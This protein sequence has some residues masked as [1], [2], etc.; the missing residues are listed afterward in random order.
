LYA[1]TGFSGS[2]PTQ[3]SITM[4]WALNPM[5]TG[6][7][8]Q[9][10]TINGSWSSNYNPGNVA[11][12]TFTGLAKD[13][14]YEF[15]IKATNAAGT[16]VES[17]YTDALLVRTLADRPLA[18]TNLVASIQTEDSLTISWTQSATAGTTQNIKLVLPGLLAPLT[19]D[20]FVGTSY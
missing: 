7:T 3:N 5:A 11:T 12:Y 13:T 17:D 6:Y 18:A 20:N 8:L 10:K 15:R 1:V 19:E 2:S 4:T 16:T 9:R 14:N